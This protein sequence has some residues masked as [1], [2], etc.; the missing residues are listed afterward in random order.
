MP[1][2]PLSPT[3]ASGS[4]GP[5]GPG[6]AA[7]RGPRAVV[8]AFLASRIVR[9]LSPGALLLCVVLF[10]DPAAALTLREAYES[11]GPR[12]G[13]DKYLELQ[14]GVTYTGGL[15]IGPILSPIKHHLV[16]PAGCDV[17]IEGNGAILDLE[18]QQL[19]ISYCQN[20][21]DIDDCI[22][23]NGNIRFRGINTADYLEIPQGS[24]RHVTFW[25]PHDYAV[26]L[27]GS[28][29][30]ILLERNLSVDPIDTG[31]DWIYTNGIANSWL[32]TGTSYSLSGQTGWYGVPVVQHNWSYLSN[33]RDNEVLLRHFSL[34]CEYG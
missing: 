10:A 15:V 28:G 31:Y 12:D 5:P 8:R 32:P 3:S 16:G 13:Y 9:A 19:C 18:G 11:A 2:S 17:R 27:Q 29:E 33:P 25:R 4:L 1:A 34:L 24:V 14:T 26:R 6:G 20:R 23:L 30:G 22:V 7:N 21:L